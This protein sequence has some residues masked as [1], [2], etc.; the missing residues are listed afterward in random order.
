[1]ANFRVH[2][3]V[4]Q[5]L[6]QNEMQIF[7]RM[8]REPL[9][10]IENPEFADEDA[11][12]KFMFSA[13][14]EGLEPI[15]RFIQA[16]ADPT[17]NPEKLELPKGA[18]LTAVQERA[19]F[20]QYN[21]C[22]YRLVG[23]ASCPRALAVDEVRQALS[24]FNKV[25]YIRDQLTN[26]NMPLV[27]AMAKRCRMSNVDFSELISEGNVA[28][29]RS[30]EKFDAG[31]GFKFSTYSCRSIL[32]AFQRASMKQNRYHQRFPA[33]FDPEMESSDFIDRR[34]QRVEADCVEA[35]R[36]IIDSNDNGADLN[37]V[38]KM[39][40]RERFAIGNDGSNPKSKTLEEFAE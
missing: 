18:R 3:R 7:S 32:K 11:E 24:W 38:E 2:A 37:E 19:M 40:I 17:G 10:Y 29:L 26:V 8:Y 13:T 5:A 30:I 14:L 35:L 39:V 33:K 20:M 28:L 12:T 27:L 15:Q 23:L 16:K 21:Y 4:A 1:M 9:D 34:R 22:R 25:E 36:G 6:S 31:R